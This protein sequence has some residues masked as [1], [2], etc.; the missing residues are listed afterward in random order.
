MIFDVYFKEGRIPSVRE[1]NDREHFYLPSFANPYFSK[2]IK[3]GAQPLT[4]LQQKSQI[5]VCSMISQLGNKKRKFVYH[6]EHLDGKKK[7]TKRFTNSDRD[8]VIHINME[9]ESAN[10]DQIEAY[11]LA[12]LIDT[13]LSNNNVAVEEA[14]TS[15]ERKL[16]QID[17]SAMER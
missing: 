1:I 2:Y 13:E 11:I 4:D 3:F 9:Q 16:E 14:I 12:R 15:A 6:V 5:E 7:R 8:Y 17:M 10:I